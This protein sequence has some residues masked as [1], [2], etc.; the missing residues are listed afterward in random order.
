[1]IPFPKEN[2]P[3][4]MEYGNALGSRISWKRIFLTAAAAYG[5][6]IRILRQDPWET[7]ITFI[8]SQRKSIP[9]IQKAVE[10]LCEAAGDRIPG[11]EGLF[12]FPGLFHLFT[13][14]P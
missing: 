2:T 7:L 5:Q 4:E 6:G 8:L 9:A 3:A 10:K 1:M 13:L 11:E 14:V 12:S